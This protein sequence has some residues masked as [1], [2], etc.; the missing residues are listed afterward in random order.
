MIIRCECGCAE[1]YLRLVPPTGLEAECVECGDTYPIGE[2]GDMA[3]E[4]H[5]DCAE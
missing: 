2:T 1:C 4:R 3:P 5:E